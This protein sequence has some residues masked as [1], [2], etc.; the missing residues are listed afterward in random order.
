MAVRLKL[1]K[2][3]NSLGFILPKEEISRLH[4][5][6]GD[7]LTMVQTEN[8][9]EISPYDQEFD[10]K[11]KAFEKGRRQYRNALRELAK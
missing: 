6:D 7:D 4:I 11:I 8:G 2:I 9:I 1:R 5:S 10:M 3:G